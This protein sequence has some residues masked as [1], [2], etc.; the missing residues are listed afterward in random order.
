VS[1]ALPTLVAVFAAAVVLTGAVRRYAL[2]RSVMD[3][4]NERS[5]H[6]VPTPR[7]GGL[8]IAATFLAGTCV[9]WAAG[10]VPPRVAAA[11]AV[12]GATIAAVGWWDDH[13]SLSVRWRLPA[14]TL[15]AALAVW[16]VGGMPAVS[17]GVAAV[18]LGWGGAVLA[19]VGVVWSLNLFNFMDGI[20]GIAGGETVTVGVA[21]GALMAILGAP[22]L[23]AGAWA[24]AA[25]AGG[26]LPWNWQRARIFMGDVGSSLL[27]FVFAVLAVASENAGSL[28]VLCWAML[29]GV[30]IFD[31]T[32]TLVRRGMRGERVFDAHRSH[33]YQRAVQAGFSHAQV[34]STVIALNLVLA[35]LAA[36]G[37]LRPRLLPAAF[38]AGLVLLCA[39]YLWVERLRPMYP[40]P[41]RAPA[42]APSARRD[43]G[44][45][46]PRR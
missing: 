8:A 26:F 10:V 7:G 37:A 34:T 23:A 13:R 45:I 22:G 11:L 12:G 28:P 2:A 31:A 16:L 29:C 18:P 6:T 32:T 21:G 25:A 3:I 19:V 40:R 4:P 36:V 15:A 41:A 24:L 27:G 44:V 33:A 5:S 43:A 39:V 46:G 35:A 14:Q 9:L 1:A 38:G 30:F 17:V 42:P 20:D